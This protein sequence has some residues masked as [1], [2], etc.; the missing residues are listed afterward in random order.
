MQ[1]SIL[2]VILL[3]FMLQSSYAQQ[4]QVLDEETHEPLAGVALYNTNKSKSALTNFKGIANISIFDRDELIHFKHVN[5]GEHSIRKSQILQNKN[6]VYLKN[7]GNELEQVVLSVAKFEMDKDEVPQKI[8]SLSAKDIIMASPQTSADL[9]ES[10]GQVFV[11]KS[12]LGG[13]SPMIRG[14]ATNR[15]LITVDGVRMNTAIFRSGN[16]QNIISI[17]PLAIGDTE[18]ILGPG[19]VVYG[20]DAIGGV[21]NFYTLKPKFSFGDNT[22]VSGS[23][24]ARYATANN[25]K[26]IHADVNIGRENWAFLSSVSFSDFDDLKMGAHGPDEYLRNEYVVRRDGQDV[27]ISNDDPRVQKPTGYEQINLLQKVKFMPHKDWDLNLGLIYSATSNFPRFDRLY[28]K[29]DGALRS[30]QWYYGPQEWFMA[31]FKINKKGDGALYDKAQM[32]AAY[33]FFE[34]SRH[35]RDFGE[36]WLYNTT[37]NVDAYSLN[38]DFEKT[39][40]DSRLFYGVEYVFNKV[41]STGFAENILTDEEQVTASRYPDD[42]TWQSIAAY[43]TYQWKIQEDLSFQSGLRYNHILV[44]ADFDE[45]LYDFPFKKANINTGALTGSAGINWQQNRFIGWRLNL[46]T[47]F[48]APNIDDVGKIFDSEP[49]AVVVPNPDLKPEYAYSSELGFDW[50]PAENISF[51]ATA[52][53]TYLNDAMVRRDFNLNGET[54]ID[55]QGEPSRVQAIQNASKAFVYGFETGV[56]I[57]FSVALRLTSQISLTEGKEEQEDGSAAALRHAAPIFGNTHLIW[58]K[59]KLKFDLFAEYNG[60]FDYE[61]LA[62]SEQGKTYLYAIDDNG[63]PYSPSWYSLNFTGQYEFSEK[64]LATASLENITNQRY[65]TYSSGIAAAGRNLVLSLRYSF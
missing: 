13:G 63:N 17:D 58:H 31:N 55:Y 49:G 35:N 38:L 57:D 28:R 10:S 22:S 18:V 56:E 3:F 6:K 60:Q 53:Y 5:F 8:L 46:S 36:D 61:D 50:K 1:N 12:Q 26:T 15:L 37:E 11:Q 25:E 4:V 39:F 7:D 34:E 43:T 24:Y 59:K 51:I 41:N 40:S 32:T 45:N 19:S 54:E 23:A 21:M 2:G 42:A 33:Q 44:N 47:A 62:P 30:A 64:L 52:F 16:L 9:L 29:R 27:A 48:R 65:R 20:S 14:F